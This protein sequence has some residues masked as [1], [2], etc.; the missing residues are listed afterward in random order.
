MANANS[1][2]TVINFGDPALN[3]SEYKDDV[4][5]FNGFNYRNSPFLSG[6]VKPLYRKDFGAKS[7]VDYDLN[8]YKIDSHGVFT[9]NNTTKAVLQSNC[10][11]EEIS[12]NDIEGTFIDYCPELGYNMF[13]TDIN[14]NP[15]IEIRNIVGGQIVRTLYFFD[16]QDQIITSGI[17]V[18]KGFIRC[19]DYVNLPLWCCIIIYKYNNNYYALRFFYN[20]N[21]YYIQDKIIYNNYSSL[22][23]ISTST[24]N[25]KVVIIPIIIQGGIYQT[26]A[27]NDDLCCFTD[28]NIPE[29]CKITEILF[30]GFNPTNNYILFDNYA[31]YVAGSAWD[32]TA[33][34][35]VTTLKLFYIGNL[36]TGT[37]PDTDTTVGRL[38]YY[39]DDQYSPT[40]KS[41]DLSKYS[42]TTINN[43]V[44]YYEKSFV[45][46][47]LGRYTLDTK[48]VYLSIIFNRAEYYSEFHYLNQA[49][50]LVEY[51]NLINNQKIPPLRI[52][53]NY[54]INILYNNETVVNVSIINSSD[55]EIRG[56]VL[57]PYYTADEI[58]PCIFHTQNDVAFPNNTKDTYVGA[59]KKGD[60]LYIIRKITGA[61]IHTGYSRFEFN[62]LNDRYLIFNTADFYNCYDIKEDYFL[63]FADDY[64]NRIGKYDINNS[65]SYADTNNAMQR[66]WIATAVNA[67]FEANK[68]VSISSQFNPVCTIFRLKDYKNTQYISV[69]KCNIEPKPE[70]IYCDVKYYGVD[71]FWNSDITNSIPEYKMTLM[72]RSAYITFLYNFGFE[73]DY[74]IEEA[75]QLLAAPLFSK[76]YQY[77]ILNYMEMG[78][79]IKTPILRIGTFDYPI[80]YLLSSQEDFDI[81]FVIQ[82]AAFG[83]KDGYVYSLVFEN[84]IL[85]NITR[86]A[87]CKGLEFIASTPLNALFWAKQNQTLYSFKGNCLFEQGQT[88]DEVSSVIQAKYNPETTEVFLCTDKY[89]LVSA[90]NYTYKIPIVCTDIFFSKDGFVLRYT[91]NNESKLSVF[92]Y[93]ED[94][95]TDQTVTRV[96]IEIET[97]YYGIGN[98]S[99]T[100]IDCVYL[101]IYN[102]LKPIGTQHPEYTTYLEISADCICADHTIKHDNG[103]IW[104][105][106][107]SSTQ[108]NR[109]V[110][111]EHNT[112]YIRWQPKI[113]N[114]VGMKIKIKTN[115][116]ITFMAV[117]SSYQGKEITKY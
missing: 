47:T 73:D 58:Y 82:T 18:V 112:A 53:C 40:I 67:F 76:F 68:S 81:F 51:G 79:F 62:V 20:Y 60:K 29:F 77:D 74:T 72:S 46:I 85:T 55:Y 41:N 24:I 116:C 22:F 48:D 90:V 28:I 50:Y 2:Q 4:K 26:L 13:F 44:V 71:L 91:E 54:G 94:F 113:Q 31:M 19:A 98:N 69:M 80:Y 15:R 56:S 16:D 6:E 42:Y 59:I 7:W 103:R 49:P 99:L 30:D 5:N 25:N 88:L 109:L 52:D 110:F 95:W 14:G 33:S 66:G 21:N 61:N 45:A 93:N 87:S 108:D 34:S 9:K 89:V 96:P 101:R 84:G 10:F 32:K 23:D 1:N 39:V 97:S 107:P 115:C 102:N 105:G 111:D 57:I 86:V 17:D 35:G 43:T 27:T 100:V 63:H 114:V 8:E 104:S 117:G 37:I 3:C 106:Q 92:T 11:L 38:V 75:N 65:I 64:N 12:L 36:V 83:I 78:D 70:T